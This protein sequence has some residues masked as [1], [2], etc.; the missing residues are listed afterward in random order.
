MTSPDIRAGVS[1]WLLH[2][3]QM[4]LPLSINIEQIDRGYQQIDWTIE[5]TGA[6]IEQ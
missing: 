4:A 2:Y 6:K 5:C 1:L 3:L